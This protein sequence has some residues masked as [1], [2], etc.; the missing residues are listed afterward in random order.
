M[1]ARMSNAP[2]AAAAWAALEQ[3]WQLA[4]ELAWEA[5]QAEKQGD[6]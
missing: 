1:T 5:F 4:F 2:E 6:T 3:P